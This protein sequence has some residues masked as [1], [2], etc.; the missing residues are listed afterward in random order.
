MRPLESFST[1]AAKRFSHSCWVSL[2]V[3]VDSFIM[4]VLSCAKA[5]GA[6]ASSAARHPPN[7]AAIAVRITFCP[8]RMSYPPLR[9]AMIPPLRQMIDCRH[10]PLADRKSMA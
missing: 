5:A 2:M 1:I 4:K 3:A 8:V 10:A 6:G 7:A 9:S